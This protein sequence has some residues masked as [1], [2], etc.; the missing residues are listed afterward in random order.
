MTNSSNFSVH[1]L[2]HPCSRYHAAGISPT[3][4]AQTGTNLILF[5]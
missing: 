4:P 5:V 2:A 3:S 1:P